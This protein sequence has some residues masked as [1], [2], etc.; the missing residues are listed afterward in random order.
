MQ[1]V[2][3]R[4][5]FLLITLLIKDKCIDLIERTSQ[6]EGS[7]YYAC[8]D[9]NAFFTSEIIQNIMHGHVKM[10]VKQ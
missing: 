3:L 1:P 5:I 9:R 10:Y 7:P 4:M 2:C 6:G 8:N